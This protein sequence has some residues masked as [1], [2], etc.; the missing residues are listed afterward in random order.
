MGTP[1]PT[2]REL[3]R[4]GRHRLVTGGALASERGAA[5]RPSPVVTRRPR[6]ATAPAPSPHLLAGAV[7][8]SAGR[9]RP[10]ARSRFKKAMVLRQAI[11]VQVSSEV[12]PD[13]AVADI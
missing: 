5:L 2:T 13:G 3:S 9:R 8:S 1:G 7:A 10:T 11:G 12:N 4:A 6:R